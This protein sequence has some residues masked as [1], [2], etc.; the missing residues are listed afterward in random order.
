MP[1]GIYIRTKPVWNK[2]LIGYNKGHPCYHNGDTFLGKKHTEETK[3]K[4]RLAK[5]GKPRLY[6]RGKNHP[7]WKGGKDIIKLLKGSIEYKQWRTKVFNRDNFTCRICEQKG[8][9]LDPHHIKPFSV[10]IE[11]RFDIDNGLT[12]CRKCHKKTDSYG[13]NKDVI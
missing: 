11:Y 2:G 4:M 7:R 3:L 9:K 6:F 8:G 12:L 10:F 1:K 13:R 5:L